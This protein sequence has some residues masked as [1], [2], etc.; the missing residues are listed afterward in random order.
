MISKAYTSHKEKHGTYVDFLEITS[1]I[2]ATC[3]T[4]GGDSKPKVLPFR[5]TYYQM[6]PEYKNIVTRNIY[7]IPGGGK[8][9]ETSLRTTTVPLC[10]RLRQKLW[11]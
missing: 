11:K 2:C 3:G 9:H 7:P 1:L 10:A 6:K 5:G 4:T 8:S